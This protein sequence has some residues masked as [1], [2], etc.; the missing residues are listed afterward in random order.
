MA[1]KGTTKYD[2]REKA[3]LILDAIDETLQQLVEKTDK[4]G[5]PF[6]YGQ[7]LKN[8]FRIQVFIFPVSSSS[9][10]TNKISLK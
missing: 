7:T 8:G 9:S 4:G 5:R 3:E 1:A 6:L 2:W 10:S